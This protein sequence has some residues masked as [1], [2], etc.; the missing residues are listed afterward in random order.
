MNGARPIDGYPGYSVDDTGN[1][2]SCWRSGKHTAKGP[3]FPSRLMKP[4]LAGNDYLTV[5]LIRDGEP[6]THYVQHLVI[7]AFGPP[8][9]DGVQQVRHLNGVRTDNR[10]ANLAWG[11]PTENA[12]D[13]IR[14]GR[15]N[16]G[17]RHPGAKL[18]PA[19]IHEIRAARAAG[20]SQK[21]IAE[22]HGV[23]RSSISGILTGRSWNHV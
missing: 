12:G 15:T 11:T 21:S 8:R 16:R 14:H 4:G 20:E 13:T 7:A 3:V 5:A 17:T 22:R 9:P 2:Y 19:D 6:R 18:A 23:T 10:I 1:V